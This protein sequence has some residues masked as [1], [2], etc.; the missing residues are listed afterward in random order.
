MTVTSQLELLAAEFEVV[1]PDLRLGKECAIDWDRS[2]SSLVR[3]R[4]R[5]GC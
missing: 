4:L 1:I 5:G 3:M 2:C